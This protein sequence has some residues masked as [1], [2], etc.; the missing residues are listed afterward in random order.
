MN[1][2]DFETE[3]ERHRFNHT[4]LLSAWNN[5]AERDISSHGY[6]SKD[7]GKRALSRQLLV[8]HGVR[9]VTS[10]SIQQVSASASKAASPYS[11]RLGEVLLYPLRT[12]YDEEP[13]AFQM[14]LEPGYLDGS[15]K[16][17]FLSAN[18]EPLCSVFGSIRSA[19]KI[20]LAESLTKAA[21]IF[22]CRPDGIDWAVINCVNAGGMVKVAKELA[23]T[24]ANRL[25]V[26]AD[27]DAK[28]PLGL[29]RQMASM[30]A[31]TRLPYVQPQGVKDWDDLLAH[32]QGKEQIQ[33]L[34]QN[35]TLLSASPVT[36]AKGFPF[37][38]GSEGFGQT[39]SYLIK[40]N[41]PEQSFG[42]C[43]GPSGVGKSFHALDWACRVA[44]GT[45][46]NGHRVRK[47]A[48]VYVAA[49]GGSMVPNRVRGWEIHHMEGEQVKSIYL[50]GQPVHISDDQECLRLMNT[51]SEIEQTHGEK[52]TL[53]VLDTLARCFAGA[54]ESRTAD[55]NLFIAG[56]D[57]IKHQCKTSILV[58]HHSGKDEGKG[59]R[60]SSAL[61]AAADFEFS[62]GKA[63]EPMTFILRNCK[64]K[65]GAETR[66]GAFR[67]ESVS[68]GKD[69]DG[70]AITTLVS[71]GQGTDV[72]DD[73]GN[74]GYKLTGNDE[75][76]YQAIRYRQSKG[77]STHRNVIRDD[78]RAQGISTNNMGRNLERLMRVGIIEL[79][80]DEF[81]TVSH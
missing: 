32:P 33:R 14:V 64:Q 52:V 65:D 39:H 47:G 75:A 36:R 73:Q 38:V 40:N 35:P 29:E 48:V 58:V 30:L 8:D 31:E 2:K 76:I 61:R 78:L 16:R 51:I 20:V 77:E 55:M 1:T 23:S 13:V 41:V 6:L 15:D 21:A 59:A 25:V 72:D 81:V 56:C 9:M 18:G 34:I 26:A 4:R 27:N 24:E 62:V 54:D 17:N 74:E 19:A 70:D 71:M 10:G 3:A 7:Q 5:S 43:F 79:K 44:T 67:M 66:P 22:S 57:R 63:E 68:L 80:N 12:L 69:Q 50:I 42:V 46:W 37:T 60:G 49:E 11:L 28:H 45:S 53:V